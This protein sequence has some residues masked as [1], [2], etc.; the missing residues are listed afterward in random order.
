MCEVRRYYDLYNAWAGKPGAYAARRVRWA[1][2]L[3]NQHRKRCSECR[4]YGTTN[5]NAAPPLPEPR[6]K[7][8]RL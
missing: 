1:R 8:M 4:G 6:L 5:F 3:I 2:E 7:G